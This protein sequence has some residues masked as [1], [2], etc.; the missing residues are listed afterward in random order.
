MTARTDLKSM[1]QAE[2]TEY[3]TS[4]GEKK[5]RAGQLWQWIHQKLAADFDEMTNLP[6]S[7][8]EKLAQQCTLTTAEPVEILTS[9]EDGTQKYLF[10]LPDG[11]VI[12]SVFLPYQH[13][14][15]VCISTQVGCRMGCAF[16]ASTL[17]GLTRNLTAGEMLEEVY[18]IQRLTG[19]RVSHVVLMGAGEPLD[20]YDAVIRFLRILSSPEG[21]QISPR[22]IT[23]STCGLIPQMERLAGEK[24]P[25]TLAIS[26][27]ASAQETRE[28]LMPIAK[29]YEIHDLVRAA[30]AYFQETGRRITFE[31]SLV[32]GVNDSEEDAARLGQLLRNIPC[33]VN[34]IPV[35][36][37][38]ERNFRQ[39][40]QSGI[41][42]FKNTLEKNGINV[43]IRREME[44]DIQG[45]CGQLRRSYL[46]QNS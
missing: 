2:L 30:G 37:I 39:S 38:K 23:L 25:L 45:A 18:R 21:L 29:R 10:R 33:H 40:T 42:N 44:R 41:R 6:G 34:L 15:S 7:L 36:P 28:K 3:L 1:T 22:S 43:T 35:N 26:L 13:G 17:N 19:Q 46:E 12:E 27:H 16:C 20:N 31:Y 4:M 32:L 5:Y 24:L 14:N 9:R 8:R 11:N